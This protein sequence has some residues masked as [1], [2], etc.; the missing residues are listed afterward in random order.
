METMFEIYQALHELAPEAHHIRLSAEL[1]TPLRRISIP[2]P[3]PGPGPDP[4][5]ATATATATAPDRPQLLF[6][7]NVDLGPMVGSAQSLRMYSAVDLLQWM[8]ARLDAVRA[9]AGV[10]KGLAAAVAAQPMAI[11]A[12]GDDVVLGADGKPLG[13]SAGPSA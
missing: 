2:G 12:G 13:D 6:S 4:D 1:N 7:A 3:G 11:P 9:A 5:P 10:Q 8:A